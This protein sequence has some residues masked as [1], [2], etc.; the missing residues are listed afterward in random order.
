[1]LSL[2]TECFTGRP[3]GFYHLELP[4]SRPAGTLHRVAK[5]GTVA[6]HSDLTGDRFVLGQAFTRDFVRRTRRGD[7]VS[8]VRP[9][10][11]DT[12]SDR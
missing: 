8:W 5:R 1:M 6:D 2:L 4:C 9:R 10:G 12:R 3:L 11:A 7:H